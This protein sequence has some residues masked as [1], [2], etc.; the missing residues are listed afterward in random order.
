MNK[1][2]FRI[3]C[4]AFLLSSLPSAEAVII[5][6]KD[7]R[8]LTDTTSI[9]YNQMASIYDVTTGA[10]LDNG[11]T[12]IDRGV[13]NGGI[14]DFAGY[15]WATIEQVRELL[16]SYPQVGVVSG[17]TPSIEAVSSAWAPQLIRDFGATRVDS[18]LLYSENSGL[19]RTIV[20][21]QLAGMTT[22]RD[23][24]LPNR[25]DSLHTNFEWPISIPVA[26]SGQWVYTTV[27]PV[28]ASVYLLGTALFGLIG[29][30]LKKKVQ[31]TA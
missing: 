11:V 1:L 27:V 14:V 7:W 21:R 16:S 26:N 23:Q 29:G 3:I 13:A 8:L 5:G 22:V 31:L 30:S 28:P 18:L 19:T 10:L 25:L 2:T 4:S 6:G 12:E 9:S 20:N 24:E 15:T 17:S